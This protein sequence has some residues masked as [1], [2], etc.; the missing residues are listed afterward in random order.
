MNHKN[1]IDSKD[2]ILLKVLELME[3]KLYNCDSNKNLE[4]IRKK[5]LLWRDNENYNIN[6]HN[7]IEN[8][9]K[10]MIR[11]QDLQFLL[12]NNIEI[13][14]FDLDKDGFI[15]KDEFK[16]MIEL[17]CEQNNIWAVEYSISKKWSNGYIQR[18]LEKSLSNENCCNSIYQHV[19]VSYGPPGSG[20]SSTTGNYLETY[21]EIG[22]ISIN[23]DDI[24]K[25]YMT[26]VLHSEDLFNDQ[27][28]YFNVRSGW[29]EYTKHKLL[30]ICLRNNYNFHVETTGHTLKTLEHIIKPVLALDYNVTILYTLVPFMELIY[31][32]IKRETLTGQGHPDFRTLLTMCKSSSFNIV[33]YKKI[34]KDNGKV[35]FINNNNKSPIIIENKESLQKCLEQHN[36]NEC[37][38]KNL[39]NKLLFK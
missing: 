3:E 31:R 34:I 33:E 22:F 10:N 25:D 11:V 27:D 36:F 29:P 20:K 21:P 9:N 4:T 5:R 8:K 26:H 6:I 13:A 14:T 32:L 28:I 18:L 1:L 37:L 39:N 15:S 16:K 23:I 30:E 2:E 12:H 17:L 35:V 38:L 24:V 19:L 7:F